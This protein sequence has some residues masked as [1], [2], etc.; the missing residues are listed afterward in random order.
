VISRDLAHNV[1]ALRRGRQLT[2][3]QLARQAGLPRSTLT[4]IESGEGNPSLRNLVRL[5][6][7]LQVGIEE[8]L[9]RPRAE[10]L[11]V[12]AGSVPVQVRGGG[13]RPFKPL[14]DSLPGMEMDR[15]ELEPGARLRG[16]PHLDR[17]REY[18][19]VVRG[20]I[21]LHVAGQGHRVRAG[22]VLAFPGDRP[23]VRRERRAAV[24]RLSPRPRAVR[25]AVRRMEGRGDPPADAA[26]LP[27]QR[28]G[29]D[30]A[31][32]A[33]LDARTVA[34]RGVAA[35]VGGDVRADRV[36]PT[37][38]DWPTETNGAASGEAAA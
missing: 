14:P 1:S 26:A 31:T 19:T 11:L 9:A 20:E 12:P 10:C 7:A 8:L 38:T 23:A 16:V 2:Q 33:R 29:I 6:A 24:D 32:D 22:D 21:V 3:A 30:A 4:W 36:A 18:L 15:L 34:R 17:T 35:G 28:R 13:A 25:A 27:G 37:L 5:S